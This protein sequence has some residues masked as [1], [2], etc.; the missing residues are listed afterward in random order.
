MAVPLCGEF[1]KRRALSFG[2]VIPPALLLLTS[3]VEVHSVSQSVPT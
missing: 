1:S 3:S 2:S